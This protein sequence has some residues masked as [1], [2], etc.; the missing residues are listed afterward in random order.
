MKKLKSI[1]ET[2]KEKGIL[3]DFLR[4][5][6]Y[7]PA[8]KYR[9]SDFSVASEPMEYM[10]VSPDPPRGSPSPCCQRPGLGYELRPTSLHPPT[11]PLGPAPV[12]QTCQP[13]DFIG[14]QSTQGPL[15]TWQLSPQRPLQLPRAGLDQRS[16]GS[17][18]AWR[19]GSG[20][21]F[22]CGLWGWSL[23]HSVRGGAW[24]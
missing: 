2:M 11:R 16:V 5:H 23:C 21:C 3:E 24:A 10:D 9:F 8:Q 13:G 20:P 18:R 22:W 19:A 14:G 17:G 7:D 12:S 6:K 4:T 1:R 15:L